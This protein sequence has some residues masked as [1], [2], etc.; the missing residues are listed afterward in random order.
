MPITHILTPVDF[1]QCA[2]DALHVAGQLA[3][4][5]NAK[6]TILHVY[7]VPIPASDIAFATDS[8]HYKSLEQEAIDKLE[9]LKGQV[10]TL[11]KVEVAYKLDCSYPVHAISAMATELNVDLI[12]MGTMGATGISEFLIGSNAADTATQA[13]C[14]VLCTSIGITELHPRKIAL[15]TDFKHTESPS[16]DLVKQLARLFNSEIEFLHIQPNPKTIDVNKSAEALNLHH[17]FA[18]IKHSYHFLNDQNITKGIERFISDK[19][20]DLLVTIHR[21]HTLF[22]RLFDTSVTKKMAMHLP[23][24]LLA[25]K[26]D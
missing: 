25:I 4:L 1:S 8:T 13:P 11:N 2:I 16:L 7:S 9:E 15:A 14:P 26:E 20:I 18:D 19:E 22:E 5:A 21:D 17:L 10:S 6:I 23:I 12:V 24:P 3:Q